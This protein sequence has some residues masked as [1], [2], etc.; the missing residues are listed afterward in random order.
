MKRAHLLAFCAALALSSAAQQ[1]PFGTLDR[2]S[3]P[4]SGAALH[5]NLAAAEHL[6]FDDELDGTKLDLTKWHG[7]YP[8]VDDKDGCANLPPLELEWYSKNNDTVSKGVLRITARKQHLHGY[9]YTS[10]MIVTGS[11]PT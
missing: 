8:Y 3:V 4:P 1:A 10:G 11:S 9:N 2:D 7:C 5:A 6:L